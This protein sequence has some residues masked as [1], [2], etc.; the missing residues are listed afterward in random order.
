MLKDEGESE[1]NSID[2]DKRDLIGE[3]EDIDVS[4]DEG[5]IVRLSLKRR[6]L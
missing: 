5:E 2:E 3:G 1:D 6:V 4:R